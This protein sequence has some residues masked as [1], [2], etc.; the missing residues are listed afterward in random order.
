MRQMGNSHF[1]T[2]SRIT[3]HLD[4]LTH[5]MLTHTHTQRPIELL[6]WLQR[7]KTKGE[8]E[9]KKQIEKGK[10]SERNRSRRERE[11]DGVHDGN[12]GTRG[13]D[14]KSVV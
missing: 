9:E 10:G 6:F 12:E 4:M 1:D 3:A 2:D 11:R 8:K 5:D 13:G 14:R 7:G